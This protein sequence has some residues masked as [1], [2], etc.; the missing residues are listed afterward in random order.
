M[1]LYFTIFLYIA[2][3]SILICKYFGSSDIQRYH[4]IPDILRRNTADACVISITIA[5]MIEMVKFYG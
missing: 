3:Y 5:I 2:W 1:I 4:C